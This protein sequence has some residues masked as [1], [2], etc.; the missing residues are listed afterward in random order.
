M[1][2]DANVG[3][4]Q[5]SDIAAFGDKAV[6]AT[7]K[8]TSMELLTFERIRCELEESLVGGAWTLSHGGCNYRYRRF[9]VGADNA[10]DCH[11]EDGSMFRLQMQCADGCP[12]PIPPHS[13]VYC[14]GTETLPDAS[15]GE[16][17]CH[18]WEYAGRGLIWFDSEY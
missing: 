18:C 1:F 3:R 11:L 15:F 4:V 8:D 7:A 16:S 14:N 12:E 5:L 17:T 13:M 6:Y 2:V 10:V 9:L